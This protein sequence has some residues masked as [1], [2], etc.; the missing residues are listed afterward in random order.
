[1]SEPIKTLIRV[2]LIFG[3]SLT[4]AL[5]SMLPFAAD[6]GQWGWSRN[7]GG[8]AVAFIL[9]FAA[10]H[11]ILHQIIHLWTAPRASLSSPPFSV[12]TSGHPNFT[13]RAESDYG[14]YNPL[15]AAM[16][17]AWGTF[18]SVAGVI[19]ALSIGCFVTLDNYW[20]FS[21]AVISS[22]V[23][24][25]GMVLVGPLAW[26]MIPAVGYVIIRCVFLGRDQ[27][28]CLTHLT[29]LQ[30]INCVLS[31]HTKINLL[32]ILFAVIVVVFDAYLIWCRRRSVDS[33]LE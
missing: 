22:G 32:V 9:V 13:A 19:A 17:S 16:G 25:L 12:G 5:V 26:M 31:R 4:I 18:Y 21:E 29:L 8:I 24:G 28:I 27:L 33:T 30:S 15:H 2:L 1:M 3:L 20:N 6:Q 11:F 7:P 14:R 23:V 10:S